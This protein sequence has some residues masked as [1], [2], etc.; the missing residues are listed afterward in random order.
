MISVVGLLS[1]I[2]GSAAAY[3]SDRYPTHIEALET[4]A[5]ILVLG[6]FAVAGYGLSTFVIV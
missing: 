5:G 2:V 3:V 1:V 6:G 4:V